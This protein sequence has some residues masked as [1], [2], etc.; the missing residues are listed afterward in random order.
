[1]AHSR[2]ARRRLWRPVFGV[3]LPPL[4]HQ[5]HKGQPMPQDP[6]TATEAPGPGGRTGGLRTIPVGRAGMVGAS[7]MATGVV[8]GSAAIL[9]PASVAAAW[10]QERPGLPG[11]S[12]TVLAPGCAVGALAA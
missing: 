2:D 10:P 7:E 9:A 11:T 6:R 3:V 8:V 4:W 1:M 12:N 5:G